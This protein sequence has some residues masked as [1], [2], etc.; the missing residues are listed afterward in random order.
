M[1]P[2]LV[3]WR[4]LAHSVVWSACTW[5][6]WNH[7]PSNVGGNRG[8]Q[9]LLALP[10]L[11]L[12]VSRTLHSGLPSR[13]MANLALACGLATLL[14]P[15]ILFQLSPVDNPALFIVLGIARGSWASL[16]WCSPRSRWRG[17][18]MGVWAHPGC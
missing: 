16:A 1:A 18:A 12:P 15:E 10:A 5:P 13:R 7:G 17:A 8:A 4:L 2:K 14:V 9:I 3:H 6:R 11:L